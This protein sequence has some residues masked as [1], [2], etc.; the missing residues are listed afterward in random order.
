MARIVWGCWAGRLVS[1]STSTPRSSWLLQG[2]G[3][4]GSSEESL[5]VNFRTYW[6][7]LFN[8]EKLSIK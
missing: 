3:I 6:L 1:I 8:E 4:P 2:T 7:T 5:K